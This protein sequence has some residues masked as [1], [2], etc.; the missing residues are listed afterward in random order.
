MELVESAESV[1]SST[2]LYL[3]LDKS[4]YPLLK[5]EHD[6]LACFQCGYRRM[7]S[8][9]DAHM[10]AA[11]RPLQTQMEE[12]T[13]L[14]S[15]GL[16]QSKNSYER[17]EDFE[18]HIGDMLAQMTEWDAINTA[19]QSHCG[20]GVIRRRC[21]GTPSQQHCCDD[22]L[23]ECKNYTRMVPRTEIDKLFRDMKDTGVSCALMISSGSIIAGKSMFDIDFREIDEE[24]IC[25]IVYVRFTQ[26]TDANQN[27]LISAIN[28]LHSM[29][30]NHLIGF[31]NSVHKHR[32]IQ[33]RVRQVGASV[34]AIV[35]SFASTEQ[36]IYQVLSKHRAAI[37]DAQYIV[38]ECVAQVI[39]D[40]EMDGDVGG[41]HAVA[42]AAAAT[43]TN[44]GA[45]EGANTAA[46]ANTAVEGANTAAV[47]NTAVEGGAA[48]V[49]NTSAIDDKITKDARD[50][51]NH[52]QQLSAEF[53][54][55]LRV[56][57]EGK[58]PSVDVMNGEHK[59]GTFVFMATK[60][61][62]NQ[63]YIRMQYM[64]TNMLEWIANL[65]EL[66][67]MIRQAQ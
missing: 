67:L 2:I 32:S 57:M 6:A 54:F 13:Q 52:V 21:T 64:S 56:S 48:T 46:V 29:Y 24:R 51:L 39:E 30:K 15:G 66:W 41:A 19:K 22:I 47:A 63:S 53:N 36:S 9:P 62:Y 40:V 59:I 20:D 34:E 25:A 10:M 31:T 38:R 18:R 11:V 7:Y 45:V 55:S 58:S 27:M 49:T 33:R 5:S 8:D 35:S 1:G 43:V 50:L 12:L 4:Q 16:K 17:G 60:T 3:Q 26:D 14:M 65:R 28:L 23:Y 61:V 44:T 42:G 37:R